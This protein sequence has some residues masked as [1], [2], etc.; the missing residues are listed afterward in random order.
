VKTDELEKKFVKLLKR[1]NV[2]V[3]LAEDVK[4][5]IDELANAIQEMKKGEANANNSQN[6]S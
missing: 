6:N 1:W 2:M 4:E 3:I 5:A